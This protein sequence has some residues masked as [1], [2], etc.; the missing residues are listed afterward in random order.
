MPI[1]LSPIPFSFLSKGTQIEIE[2]SH[3][4]ISFLNKGTQIEVELYKK[5]TES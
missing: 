3:T 4:Q 5:A 1:S 2:L